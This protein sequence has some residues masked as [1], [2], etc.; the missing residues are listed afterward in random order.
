MTIFQV[1]AD[2]MVGHGTA[3]GEK[4]GIKRSIVGAHCNVQEKVKIN[5]SVIMD[6]V[7]VHEGCGNF[8]HRSNGFFVT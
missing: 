8:T 5:N 4:V 1:G 2:S 7:K 3:V 6:S